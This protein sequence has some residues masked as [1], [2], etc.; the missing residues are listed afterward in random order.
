HQWRASWRDMWGET[1]SPR[2]P[3]TTGDRVKPDGRLAAPRHR[4]S[5][6]AARSGQEAEQ[7]EHEN[8]RQ[9]NTDQPQ[10]TTFEHDTVLRS[11]RVHRNSGRST[12]FRRPPAT[13]DNPF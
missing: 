7:P 10:K 3:V 12:W 5:I 6:C 2:Y 13:I 9:R 11:C 8:D 4:W 1:G